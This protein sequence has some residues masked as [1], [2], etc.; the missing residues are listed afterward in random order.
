LEEIPLNCCYRNKKK[1]VI[2]ILK[3]KLS[4]LDQSP[5]ASGSTHSEALQQTIKLAQAADAWGFTRYWIAEHHN[6]LG[7]A[8]S[9]P[10]VL[11]STLGAKTSRIRIG[12]GGVLLPHYSAY[13]IAENFRMLEALYP[14]R[15]DLGIGRA[16]GGTPHTAKALRD[17]KADIF[18]RLD[19][20]PEQVSDLTAF[21]TDSLGP[22]HRYEGIHASPLIETIPQLW[23]LGSSS[24]GGI[25]AAEMGAAYCFAHFINSSGGQ[26]VVHRYMREFRP[27]ALNA[28]AQAMVAIFVICAETEKEAERLA[29]SMDLSILKVE[30]G[31]RGGVPSPQEAADYPYTE[32]D[33]VR[34]R[35]NRSRMLVGDPEQ[36]K[37]QVTALV[38]SYGTDEV[39][40]LTRA[41]DFAARLRSYELL[42]DAFALK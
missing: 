16:P 21:L 24:Q 12:S 5:V 15:I 37:R 42:A 38:E 26:Q 7:L 41:H 22:G 10:E 20:F 9:S 2:F 19:R 17:G 25:Y 35:E 39:M 23:M 14:G 30:K 11:I 1:K 28:Q 31:E 8:S 29:A 40:I 13:K 32:R 3:L 36:V 18:E 27:N 34:I 6:T 4:I 33:R